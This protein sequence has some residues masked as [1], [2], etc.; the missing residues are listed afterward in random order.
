MGLGL[1]S[2]AIDN[3]SRAFIERM[4]RVLE[5][6]GSCSQLEEYSQNLYPRHDPRTPCPSYALL[7]R[8]ASPSIRNMSISIAG[9]WATTTDQLN[10]TDFLSLPTISRYSLEFESGL[11]GM[12]S[13]D[14]KAEEPLVE[15]TVVHLKLHRVPNRLILAFDF[16]RVKSFK[17]ISANEGRDP[18]IPLI[19]LLGRFALRKLEELTL[20]GCNSFQHSPLSNVS[21]DSMISL[22]LNKS[23]TL[24]SALFD[25]ISSVQLPFP[26]LTHLNLDRTRLNPQH[27][28]LVGSDNAPHLTSL[29]LAGTT[30]TSFTPDDFPIFA[31]LETLD[32]SKTSWPTNQL[33]EDLCTKTPAIIRLSL[34]GCGR[35]ETALTGF[36]I[37]NLVKSRRLIPSPPIAPAPPSWICNTSSFLS[38]APPPAPTAPSTKFETAMQELN[39]KSLRGLETGVVDWLRANTRKGTV[40][41]QFY[42]RETQ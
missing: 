12:Y 23:S 42:D 25:S 22:T 19:P 30:F 4:S 39:L 13:S 37:V 2:I 41:F 20:D 7:R 15:S 35:S 5:R 16:P 17:Y 28:R 27:L 8:I 29:H 10:W 34:M 32:L 33:V 40:S 18:A 6:D 14:F 26:V 36:P 3:A 11:H 31:S 1:R 38:P 24:A 21:F 9:M